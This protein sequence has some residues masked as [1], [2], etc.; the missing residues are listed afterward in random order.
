[1]RSK[2]FWALLVAHN[3]ANFGYWA[4]LTQLPSD[5]DKMLHFDLHHVS[6]ITQESH[7]WSKTVWI[8]RQLWFVCIEWLAVLYSIHCYVHLGPT[9]RHDS[10]QGHYKGEDISVRRQKSFEHY[11]WV[12]ITSIASTWTNTAGECWRC[13]FNDWSPAQGI[14]AFCLVLIGYVNGSKATEVFLFSLA[15]MFQGSI[16]SG[17]IP[18]H[19]DL[20]PKFAGDKT[21]PF[22]CSC[23]TGKLYMTSWNTWCSGSLMG[24]TNTAAAIVAWSAPVIAGWITANDVSPKNWINSL[25]FSCWNAVR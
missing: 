7:L 6:G 1:M 13:S 3:G 18:N 25:R 16:Y 4:L 19:V 9:V 5:L 20:A 8:L 17:C 14:P 12:Y 10:G 21:Q 15:G 23:C 2:P 22:S 24:I 11:W